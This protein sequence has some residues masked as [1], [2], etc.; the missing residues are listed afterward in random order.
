M[1]ENNESPVKKSYKKLI[2]A[3]VAVVIIGVVVAVFHTTSQN[4]KKEYIGGNIL[5]IGY[6]ISSEFE[7]EAITP[8]W[9]YSTIYFQLMYRTLAFSNETATDYSPDMASDFNV[10]ADGLTYT[11]TLDD[12][13]YWSDGEKLTPEDVEFTFR[14]ILVTE[15]TNRLFVRAIEYIEG[16]QESIADQSIPLAGFSYSGNDITITLS[17]P[18]H[19]FIQVL[20][21]IVILPEHCFTTEDILNG[22]ADS[23]YWK[24]PIVSGLYKIDSI[25]NDGNGSQ[26]FKLV[27]NDKYAGEPAQIDEVRILGLDDTTFPD[28]YYT[29]NLDEMTRYNMNKSYSNIPNFQLFYKYLYFNLEGIDGFK[30]EAMDNIDVRNAI[31]MAI[32]I[33]TIFNDVFLADGNLI[34]SGVPTSFDAYVGNTHY[35]DPVFA[36]ELLSNSGYDLERPIRISYYYSDKTSIEFITQVRFYLEA[37]GLTVETFKVTDSN[38]ELYED[39]EFDISYKG[40]SAFL[41]DEW[42]NELVPGDTNILQNNL[43]NEEFPPLVEQLMETINNSGRD[44]ILRELQILEQS[45]SYKIPIYTSNFSLYINTERVNLPDDIVFGNVRYRSKLKLN[46]WEINKNITT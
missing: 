25:V 22:I 7:R 11:M 34:Y 44:N 42:Y 4:S 39:R 14:S 26:Y 17:K 10:S 33:E 24:A 9:N 2:I 18:Y 28:Y 37:I 29:S 27:P 40:L 13:I 16:A 45:M 12:N 21:Q 8:V 30:N 32:D 23:D 36:K 15:A 38:K 20:S 6:L 46:E 3:V 31:T 5:N 35:Y 41:V 19:S 1:N 43:H